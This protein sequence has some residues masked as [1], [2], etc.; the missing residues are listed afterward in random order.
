M[1]EPS[2][3]LE[4]EQMALSELEAASAATTHDARDAH[5]NKAAEYA[6]LGEVKTD[7]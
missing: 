1:S 4:Y 2:T 7:G 5:L 3:K 6:H